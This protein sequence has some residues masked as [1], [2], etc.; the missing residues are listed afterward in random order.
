MDLIGVQ[1]MFPNIYMV[2]FLTYCISHNIDGSEDTLIRDC[3]LR[4][5]EEE[6]RIAIAMEDLFADLEDEVGDLSPFSKPMQLQSK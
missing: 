6:G 2:S 1:H 5:S 3:I 4:T